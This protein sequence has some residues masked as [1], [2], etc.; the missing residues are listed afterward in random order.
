VLYAYGFERIGVVISDL[1]FVDPRPGPGQE[2][3]ERG[4]RLEVRM[5]G[6]GDLKGS[7]YSARPIEVGEPVWRADLLEA[8]DGPPGSLNRAHHHPA[9]NGWEPG[10]RVF[11]R[12][13]SAGPVEWVGEQLSDLGALLERAAVPAAGGFAADAESL[14]AS[15]PEIKAT[16]QGLLDRIK[17]GEL[18]NAPAGDQP[19]SARVSWL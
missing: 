13:L 7:I 8:A 16:V 19:E 4:V 2:G 17:A 6:Q 5:L 1:Y 14:R 10:K 12:S 3:A 15:V 11:D 9:F 18:A